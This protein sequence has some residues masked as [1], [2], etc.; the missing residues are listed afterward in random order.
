MYIMCD[1]LYVVACEEDDGWEWGKATAPGQALARSA[2]K[3]T[4]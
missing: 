3:G 1:V 2:K 4:T